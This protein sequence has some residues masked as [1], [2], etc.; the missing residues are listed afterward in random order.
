MRT[1][2]IREAKKHLSRLIERAARGEPFVI[3]KAGKPLVKVVALDAPSLHEARRVGFMAGQF[4]V[5]D[6][7]DRMAKRES[8]GCSVVT[9]E[10]SARHPS[11]PLGGG[12][13]CSRG[14]RVARAR[15]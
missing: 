1:A 11:S 4:K 6:D 12:R 3:V 7:F 2:N 8:N 15:K 13:T 10:A 14:V 5:P 9:R